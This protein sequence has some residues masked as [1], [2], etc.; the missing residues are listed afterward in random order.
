MSFS[1][2]EK[3]FSRL[4]YHSKKRKSRSLDHLNLRRSRDFYYSNLVINFDMLP[5]SSSIM[6]S[7]LFSINSRAAASSLFQPIKLDFHS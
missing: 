7:T 5:P 1:Y 3:L 2:S 4:S 6:E